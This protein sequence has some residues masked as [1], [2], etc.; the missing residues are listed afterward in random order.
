MRFLKKDS[1]NVLIKLYET[2]TNHRQGNNIIEVAMRIY[3]LCIKYYVTG[4][5]NN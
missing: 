3:I 4:R 5:L 1:I 2:A